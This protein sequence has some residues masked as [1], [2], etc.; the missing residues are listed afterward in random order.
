MIRRLRP[1]LH[2][3]P[4]IGH[5]LKLYIDIPLRLIKK[6]GRSRIAALASGQNTFGFHFVA[7]FHNGYKAVAPGSIYSLGVA[8]AT[9]TECR[10][11]PPYTGSKSYG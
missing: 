8:D 11:T 3:L 2:L 7:K 1:F 9:H 5:V 10:Q 4:V 6:V